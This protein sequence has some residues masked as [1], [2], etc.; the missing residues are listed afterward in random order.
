MAWVTRKYI[1]KVTVLKKKNNKINTKPLQS[2]AYDIR[3]IPSE[4]FFSPFKL[5]F[6]T[7]GEKRIKPRAV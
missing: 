1:L 7:N 6:G 5:Y 4:Y 3:S 2:D